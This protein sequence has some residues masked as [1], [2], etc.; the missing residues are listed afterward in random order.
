[1][2]CRR[3]WSLTWIVPPTTWEH[4][5]Q[6][7]KDTQG[8]NTMPLH[9]RSRLLLLALTLAYI[10]L[11]I[12]GGSNVRTA[13]RV[14]HDAA[15][16]GAFV[17]QHSWAI[18]WGSFCEFLSAI[19]L[20]IFMAVSIGWL[21]VPGIR[22]AGEP[23]AVLGGVATPMMMVGSA[24]ATWSLTRPGVAEAPGAVAALQSAGFD[25]GGPG[26]ALFLGLFIAGVSIAAG[27][28]RLLPWWLIWLG[29]V[30]AAAGE[31]SS[32]TLLNFTAGYFIPV[33]RL[34]SIVW[35]IGLSFKLPHDLQSREDAGTGE[36]GE[37]KH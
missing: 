22:S 19:P 36:A 2:N 16:A 21:R 11:M 34:V 9:R 20:G 27:K 7:S 6:E 1:M 12:L 3:S 23:I 24:L 30:V 25:G 17:A 32:L 31:L 37:P 15:I 5:P 13:F 4:S 33:A 14:P 26:F 35:M 10:A 8:E 28:S 18:R 29:I